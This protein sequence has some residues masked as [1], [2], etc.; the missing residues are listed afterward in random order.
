MLSKDI[1]N[2]QYELS[3]GEMFQLDDFRQLL[4]EAIVDDCCL[5]C[6][7]LHVANCGLCWE[8]ILNATEFEKEAI[9]KISKGYEVKVEVIKRRS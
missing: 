8:C 1:K 5:K 4:K 9:E 6:G 7:G 3:L 2:Y